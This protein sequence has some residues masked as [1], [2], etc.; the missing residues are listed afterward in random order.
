M[1]VIISRLELCPFTGWAAVY[2][3]PDGTEERLF[4]SMEKANRLISSFPGV[5]EYS[6]IKVG[7]SLVLHIKSYRFNEG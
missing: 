5:S 4:C 2:A 6:E 1:N 7:R 3:L